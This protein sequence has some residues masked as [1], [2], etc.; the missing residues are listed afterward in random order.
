MFDRCAVT[1]S[2]CMAGTIVSVCNFPEP[3]LID[4]IIHTLTELSDHSMIS[5]LQDLNDGK[6][7]SSP[8]H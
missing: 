4:T 3:L 6:K 2:V 1:A 8:L 7:K 5:F